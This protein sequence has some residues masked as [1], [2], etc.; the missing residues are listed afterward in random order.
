MGLGA[1]I[2]AL[3]KEKKLYQKDLGRL[4]G[5]HEKL[6]GKYENEQIIP[7]ADTLRKIAEALGVSS[8]YLI[9]DNV[10]KERKL[11]ILDLGLYERFRK[12]ETLDDADKETIKKVIDAVVL[13]AKVEKA[14]R[15]AEETSSGERLKKI[16]KKFRE[17][18][19]GYSEE[20]IEKIVD[21]AVK[22]VRRQKATNVG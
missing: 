19:K 16:L 1:K 22:S 12:A 9:F 3:R 6:I 8:D 11:V 14:I 15:P 17:K 2:R 18:S 5:V 7:T 20:E 4:A 13:K 10:P 21:K